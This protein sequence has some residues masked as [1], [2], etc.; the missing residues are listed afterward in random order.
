MDASSKISCAETDEKGLY[1]GTVNDLFDRRSL[2]LPPAAEST[3]ISA[4]ER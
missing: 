4:K 3:P 2:D 1:L